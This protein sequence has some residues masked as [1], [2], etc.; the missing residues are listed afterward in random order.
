MTNCSSNRGEPVDKIAGRNQVME[1]LKAGRKISRLLI[2]EGSRPK[3]VIDEA[4]RKGIPFEYV[5]RRRLD[6]LVRETHQGVVALA[7]P[8]EYARVEDLL[9]AARSQQEPA[10]IVALDGVE[11]PHNLG[12]VIRS[13]DVLGA[14]G[15]LIPE[16]RA[17]GLSTAVSRASAGAVE[18]VKV[19]RVVNLARAIDNMKQ[20]GLWAIGLDGSADKMLWQVDF[21]VPTLLVVGGE[22]KGLGRLIG[23]KCDITARIPMSGRVTSLN[24]SVA[25][26]LALYEVRRQ[27]MNLLIR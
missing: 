24:A 20:E 15:V 12:S 18:H 19:A 5:D 1:A 26:A 27:R 10:L 17:A 4:R 8:V 14:H 22:G 11:D 13:V 3:E 9:Q 25:A 16:R 7:S 23:Q 6:T 2:S 21:T